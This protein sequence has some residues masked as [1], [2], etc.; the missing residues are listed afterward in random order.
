MCHNWCQSTL[1]KPNNWQ[2]RD[3]IPRDDISDRLLHLTRD[4]NEVSAVDGLKSILKSK[5]I[6][7]SSRDVRGGEKCVCFTET[8]I[9]KI[10][11]LVQQTRQTNFRY[12][13]FG[14]MA[15]K[16]E[17]FERGGRPAIYGTEEEFRQLPD[18][19]KFRFVKFDYA[20]KTDWTW[21]R[22][23]RFSGDTYGLDPAST[24]VIVPNRNWKDRIVDEYVSQEQVKQRTAMPR[25][26]LPHV[27]FP[28][29]IIT[30]DDLGLGEPDEDHKEA[31]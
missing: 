28:W 24:T 16:R 14:V 18:E 7:G 6:N 17:V 10:A 31:Q 8:P 27:I 21:E 15:T 23:W 19:F 26:P 4:C 30:F 5:Q 9:A 20:K 1:K 13:A 3:L 12:G 22:E 25:F 29:N 2:W 11:L